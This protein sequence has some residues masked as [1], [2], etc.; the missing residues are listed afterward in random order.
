MALFESVVYSLTKM[1]LHRW[2][3]RAG[4]ILG[5]AGCEVLVFICCFQYQ[6]TEHCDRN[7]DFFLQKLP[8]N[9]AFTDTKIIPIY[10]FTV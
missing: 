4:A 7:F 9:F 8:G 5:G 3:K 1:N 6:N 2:L 10:L